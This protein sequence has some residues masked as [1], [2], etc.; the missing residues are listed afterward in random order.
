MCGTGALTLCALLGHPSLHA[1]LPST[2]TWRGQRVCELGAG[3]GACGIAAAALGADSVLLTDWLPS[4]TAL[5]GDNVAANRELFDRH[6]P[7]PLVDSALYEWGADVQP[8]LDS[9]VAV[10]SVV[11]TRSVGFDVLLA[12]ECVYDQRAFQ[13][14]LATLD[15]LT[16]A[17]RDT[18]LLMAYEKRKRSQH[19]NTHPTRPQHWHRYG[20][21][22]TLA[23]PLSSHSAR[24][25][26]PLLTLS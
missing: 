21:A 18:L 1:L 4:F 20:T 13:P 9:P 6:Q 7:P 22:V 5:I 15:A 10:G 24:S 3:T 16:A 23:R 19:C 11:G 17:N 26:C 2:G 25:E 14:L 8:L 12:S